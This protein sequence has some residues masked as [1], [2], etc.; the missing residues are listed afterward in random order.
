LR[1]GDGKHP[2]PPDGSREIT[3]F[4][5]ILSQQGTTQ[6]NNIV[7]EWQQGDKALWA[8]CEIATAN[9][10]AA[11]EK[12]DDA[13][14]SLVSNG[15][16]QARRSVIA[17]LESEIQ[18]YA[19]PDIPP[20]AAWPILTVITLSEVWFNYVAFQILNMDPWHTF[21]MA[22][23]VLLS[24]VVIPHFMGVRIKKGLNKFKHIIMVAL[25][26]VVVTGGFWGLSVLREKF[27]ETS[28]AMK[29]A[30]IILEPGQVGNIMMVLNVVICIAIIIIAHEST[31]PDKGK[32]RSLVRKRDEKIREEEKVQT[33]LIGAEKELFAAW[34]RME[35]AHTNRTN[36][37]EGM[38]AS[39][40]AIIDQVQYFIR[41]YRDLNISNRP[42]K[43]TPDCWLNDNGLEGIEREM[44]AEMPET[45]KSLHGCD[46]CP[47][48]DLDRKRTEALKSAESR[49]LPEGDG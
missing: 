30:G 41:C 5:K 26:G 28:E 36:T 19:L 39:T 8:E 49:D 7:H 38:K 2:S 20:L 18:K 10:H 6:I 15:P 3:Q 24:F 44:R 37:Y 13:E 23:G 9:Y 1:E 21:A 25:G 11:R 45:I 48:L 17:A 46:R 34:I 12:A 27:I 40:E 35:K 43:Q 31:M 32:Y 47:Y 42:E 4:E 22:A 14:V 33:A 29:L 16:A